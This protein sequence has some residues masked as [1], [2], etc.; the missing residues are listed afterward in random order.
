MDFFV[1]FSPITTQPQEIE[2]KSFEMIEEEIGNHSFSDAQ[3]P[4]VKR[5]IHTTADFELGESLQFHPEAVKA[6]IFAIRQG[7]KIVTDVEMVKSGIHQSRITHFGGQIICH[8][9]DEDVVKKAKEQNT[10]RSIIAMQ[11]AT[12]QIEGGI[13]AIG[14]AP[15]ALLELIRLIK[16]E[17]AKPDLII[18]VPVGFVSAKESK[19]ELQKLDVPYITN[20]GR[21]GGSP[22][23]A[24]IVNALSLMAQQVDR[25]V[26]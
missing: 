17:K 24:A 15:T 21:K 1:E 12:S 23:A 9:R 22:V 7:K 3:F 20:Q 10:T 26:E 13:F 18:G 19:E 25:D 8:I 6:G 4:I 11:K 16:L 5:V 2:L 14:N